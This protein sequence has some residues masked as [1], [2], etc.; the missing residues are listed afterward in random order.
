MIKK[1]NIKFMLIAVAVI[2]LCIFIK[3]S[4]INEF[5]IP[6]ESE[7]CDMRVEEYNNHDGYREIAVFVNDITAG[8]RFSTFE[9]CEYDLF[10]LL[11]TDKSF[12]I[13]RQF[14]VISIIKQI[15]V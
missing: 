14:H 9:Y 7:Y 5:V 6:V 2:G 12:C 3:A 11:K 1:K 15:L 10:A 8:K 4:A 13:N